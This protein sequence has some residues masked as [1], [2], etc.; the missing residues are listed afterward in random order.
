MTR[1]PNCGTTK[2]GMKYFICYNEKVTTSLWR[3]NCDCGCEFKDTTKVVDGKETVVTEVLRGINPDCKYEVV[4]GENHIS[5]RMT[6]EEAI[7]YT[8]R[9]RR[10][11]PEKNIYYRIARQ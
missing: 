6:Q 3:Y 11:L 7:A 4:V 2:P 1:C 5:H 8:N 10:L 9:V